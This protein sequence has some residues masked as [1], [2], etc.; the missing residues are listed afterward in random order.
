MSVFTEEDKVKILSDV[1]GIKTVN[2]NEIEVCQYFYH[3]FE[4]HGIK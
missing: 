3:L 2:D 1:I 4:K